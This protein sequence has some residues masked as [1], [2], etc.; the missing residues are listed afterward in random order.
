MK[1]TSFRPK[2][3]REWLR[4]VMVGL[5]I[6]LLCASA[7]LF[8]MLETWSR[9]ISDRLYLPYAADSRIVLV[10][11]DDASMARL[12]RWPWDRSVHGELIKKIASVEPLAIGYDVNF[13]EASDDENDTA[14]ANSIKEAGNVVLPV[15]LD[16]TFDD[17]YV[18]K[19]FLQP[20]SKIASVAARIGHTNT[21]QDADGVVRRVPLSVELMDKSVV[22]AFAFRLL[23]VAGI[24][25]SLSDGTDYANRLIVHYP[26]KPGVAYTTVSAADVIDSSLVRSELRNKF[27]LV[28]ATAAD[29]HDNQRVPTSVNQPMDGVEIHASILNTLL[30]EK[31]LFELPKWILALW[32]LSIALLLALLIPLVRARW[33]VP[34]VF[35]LWLGSVVLAFVCFDRGLIVDILW[36]TIT[37]ILSFAAVMMERRIASERQ[38]KEIKQAFSHYVSSSVVESILDDP[39][40]LQL[41]GVRK[42]MTVM[43]S[44]VRGFTTISEGLTPEA[45]V[46]LMNTY[47]TRMTDIVFEHEG[48][49]DKYIGDAVM[50][51]WN[52]PFDQED[53][54]KRAVDTALDMLS[55]LEQMNRE[56]AFGD[57]ELRIGVGVNSGE[58]VVG[59]MGSTDRFD[60]TV[61]GD[62]V[63]LGSRMEALTKQYGIALLVSESTKNALPE[64][65]YLIRPIDLV[66]VKGKNKPIKMYEVLKRM[67]DAS[68]E[69]KQLVVVFVKA[70]RAYFARDFFTAAQLTD[71]LM[72]QF[73]MD[74]PSKTLNERA[75]HFSKEPP[76]DDWNGAWVMK[77]K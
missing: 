47:L 62:N 43:F 40:Q 29:L 48:V 65:E 66:T 30:Q 45:L 51:F 12:G 42:D 46:K 33:S 23:E 37:I 77:T 50:A 17:G 61:I 18:A 11:I 44:D 14:L 27:V 7:F 68:E 72:M 39:K 75:K 13:P 3:L 57:L 24:K 10:A 5:T 41:G 22:P 74:G 49:L 25:A 73:P 63:N 70:L 35:L 34:L 59:N 53:H 6:G 8:G 60:Y 16:L 58:M 28:G 38:K 52:A 2:D 76:P 9:R 32:I 1:K 71:Q 56:K 26:D 20:I 36:I 67:K 31:Y 19:R 54:A 69:N 15:E 4:P 55:A 21:P 64:G